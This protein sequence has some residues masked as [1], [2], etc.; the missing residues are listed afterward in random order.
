M[1]FSYVL[2]R[3]KQLLSKTF[4]SEN[5]S[6]KKYFGSTFKMGYSVY[7]DAISIDRKLNIAG[8][9]NIIDKNIE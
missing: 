6:L 1:E 5:A 2:L 4:F 9:K 3:P 7:D 8:F